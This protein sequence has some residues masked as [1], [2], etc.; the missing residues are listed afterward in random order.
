[1]GKSNQEVFYSSLGR[2]SVAD[3]ATGYRLGGLRFEPGCGEE[4]LSFPHPSRLALRTTQP[5]A[6]RATVFFPADKVAKTRHS[7]T[8]PTHDKIKN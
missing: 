4:M 6:Q 7:T 3:I 2:D 5:L 8:T 1:M